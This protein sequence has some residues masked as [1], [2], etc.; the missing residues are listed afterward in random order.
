[1]SIQSIQ[2]DCY[3][4]ILKYDQSL[5]KGKRNENEVLILF[6]SMF[7]I[8]LQDKHGKYLVLG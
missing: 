1:M 8:K 4:H 5:S 7:D 2:L 6:K 3:A